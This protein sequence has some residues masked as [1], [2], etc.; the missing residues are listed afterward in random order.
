MCRPGA[1]PAL[2]ELLLPAIEVDEALRQGLAFARPALKLNGL[3]VSRPPA[4]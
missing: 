1:L 2:T 3:P 4:E